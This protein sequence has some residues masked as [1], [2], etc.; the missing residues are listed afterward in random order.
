MG[1]NLPSRHSSKA[2]WIY[3]QSVS[4]GLIW[5]TLTAVQVSASI[6]VETAWV[7]LS[8]PGYFFVRPLGPLKKNSRIT[9]VMTGFSYG[10]DISAFAP[11]AHQWQRHAVI[12]CTY[13]NHSRIY[14]LEP[15]KK[16]IDL[17]NIDASTDED[18]KTLDIVSRSHFCFT[19]KEADACI[20]LNH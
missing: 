10:L 7:V 13:T 9:S 15:I 3:L 12:V 1:L 2:Q 8:R 5:I 14:V 4:E 19:A 11:W 17:P 18:A 20:N 6:A 16:V